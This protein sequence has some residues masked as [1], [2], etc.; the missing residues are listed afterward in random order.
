MHLRVCRE[1][2]GH[3]E[4]HRHAQR[5]DVSHCRPSF[6]SHLG[7]TLALL[8]AT[9]MPKTKEQKGAGLNRKSATRTRTD[10]A[11]NSCTAPGTSRGRNIGSK[12]HSCTFANGGGGDGGNGD[13]GGSGKDK[14]TNNRST[15]TPRPPGPSK[16]CLP[17][18]GRRAIYA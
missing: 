9:P 7:N 2:K 6:L 13:N 15:S 16:V 18:V 1:G 17:A 4:K 12:D 8:H 5:E 11:G 14:N 3:P 10:K